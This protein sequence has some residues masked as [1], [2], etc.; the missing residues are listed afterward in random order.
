MFGLR[1]QV[2]RRSFFCLP[3]G[4]SRDQLVAMKAQKVMELPPAF[5]VA[6]LG[7]GLHEPTPS[8]GGRDPF[9]GGIHSIE[10]Q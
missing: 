5:A 2:M 6:K 4:V 10:E 8:L 1:T 7:V 9:M 3:N